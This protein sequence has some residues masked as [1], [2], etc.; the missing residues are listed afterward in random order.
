MPNIFE[1]LS[2]GKSGLIA[3]LL[4][5]QTSGQNISNAN[6]EGYSRQ[7]V[8]MRPS[9][10]FSHVRWQVGS[11]VDVAE[12][13]RIRDRF[14]DY[15]LREEIQSSGQWEIK[16]GNLKRIESIINEP[17]DS[18]LNDIMNKFW[19]AWNDLANNPED[20]L[21]RIEVKEKGLS[22]V[23][24]FN[25]INAR[26]FRAR[27]DLNE[28]IRIKVEEINN[29]IQQIA[30]LNEQIS[31]I[32]VGEASANDF[33][34]KRDLLL[35]KLA[36]TVGIN[37]SERAD[38]TVSVSLYGTGMLL[39][40]GNKISPLSTLY[41]SVNDQVLINMLD[42]Q[43]TINEGELKGYLDARNVPDN[44]VKKYI[45]ELDILSKE[46]IE[47]VNRLHSRGVGLTT[48]SSN[49]SSNAVSNAA[50]PINSAGL[51]YTPVDGSFRLYVFDANG[52]VVSSNLVSIDADTTTLNDIQSQINLIPN[53]AANISD[54]KLSITS[55]AG[56]TFAFGDDSS[57]VLVALGMNTFF[58]G[59]DSMTININSVIQNDVT[60]I[61]TGKVELPGIFSPGDNRIAL[62]VAH[63]KEA[64]TMASNTSTFNDYYSS[65]VGSLGTK[66][67]EA[68][69]FLENQKLIVE[70]LNNKRE[71]SSG[72]NLDEELI[73]MIKYQNAYEAASKY[74]SIIDELI[75]NL[76]ERL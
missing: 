50:V 21:S 40:D 53:L 68:S 19:K 5:L 35:G 65:V 41:D 72:V 56:F 11:G 61:A 46:L 8:E 70:Q 7:R 69:R 34:D 32:E 6:T 27:N 17:S 22:L 2:A 38:G 51:P 18:G 10:P 29:Y 45:N 1:S 12:I 25:Q 28:G 44:Y 43:V 54:N 16:E 36:K 73:D 39:V 31:Q 3:Q 64:L 13:R 49:T 9:I 67:E 63:L 74:I 76:I 15:Q 66:I 58:T 42:I 48:Y 24:T 37:V 60:K 30:D 62:D 55:S 57:D 47:E 14:V 23:N 33:R 4:A 59:Y 75:E 20:Q 52:A 71:E 26:L